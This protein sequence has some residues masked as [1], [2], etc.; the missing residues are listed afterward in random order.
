LVGTI[1]RIEIK[2]YD[3]E[4]GDP[5]SKFDNYSPPEEGS[6]T[7]TYMFWETGVGSGTVH[8]VEDMFASREEAEEECIKRNKK[9]GK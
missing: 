1:G 9:E 7:E 4:G 5:D 8:N 6:D 2:K 3:Y